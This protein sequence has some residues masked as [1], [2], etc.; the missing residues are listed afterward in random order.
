MVVAQPKTRH[1]RPAVEGVMIEYR[2]YCINEAGR[3]TKAHEIVASD[4]ADALDQARE[5]HLEV[6]CELW[7]KGR[8]VAVLQPVKP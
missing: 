1:Y 8:K 3:F 2:L 4:D 6:R 5:M 7:E